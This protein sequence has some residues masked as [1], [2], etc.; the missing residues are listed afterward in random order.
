M[1]TWILWPSQDNKFTQ[2]RTRDVSLHLIMP[3]TIAGCFQHS[4]EYSLRTPPPPPLLHCCTITFSQAL[5][6]LDDW[7][8]TSTNVEQDFLLPRCNPGVSG[9]A[10]ILSADHRAKLQ[11]TSLSRFSNTVTNQSPVVVEVVSCTFKWLNFYLERKI[12]FRSNVRVL[13]ASAK[14]LGLLRF[15]N[16]IRCPSG[17]AYWHQNQVVG[18]TL[19]R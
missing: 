3:I 11:K 7:A 16:I 10:R 15:I 14:V 13:L 4:A 17:F 9:Q 1:T 6:P 12:G 8:V 2:I 19:S 5:Q 18:C